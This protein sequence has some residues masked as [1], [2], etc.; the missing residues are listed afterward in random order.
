MVF[1]PGPQLIA[2]LPSSSQTGR[3][4]RLTGQQ[5]WPAADGILH[6]SLHRSFHAVVIKKTVQMINYDYDNDDNNN[7][8]YYWIFLFFHIHNVIFIYMDIILDSCPA[9][10]NTKKSL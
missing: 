6:G 3:P 8:R 1:V 2:S 4:K 7:C 9:K 5:G 10:K